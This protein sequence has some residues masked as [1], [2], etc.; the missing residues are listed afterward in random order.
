MVATG[1]AAGF[2]FSGAPQL[3]PPAAI[4]IAF[5]RAAAGERAAIVVPVATAAWAGAAVAIPFGLP[6]AIPAAAALAAHAV[7]APA[8]FGLVITEPGGDLVA[9]AVEKAAIVGIITAAAPVAVVVR[10]TVAGPSGTFV[11]RSFARIKTV[12]GHAC[13]PYRASRLGNRP[14]TANQ[15]NGSQRPFR[16]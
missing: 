9:G 5:A 15:T 10:M 11:A 7:L 12:I 8:P 14:I 4:V 6:I 1:V 3:A 13:S 2:A 16:S